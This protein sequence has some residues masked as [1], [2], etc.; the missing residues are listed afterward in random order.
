MLKK[1]QLKE[2]RAKIQRSSDFEFDQTDIVFFKGIS[3][4][5]ATIQVTLQEPGYEAVKP[6]SVAITVVH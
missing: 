5:R 6:A 2:A 3:P 1:V 4:G